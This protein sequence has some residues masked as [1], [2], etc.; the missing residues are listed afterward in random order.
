MI[1]MQGCPMLAYLGC[2]FSYATRYGVEHSYNSQ[3]FPSEAASKLNAV[4]VATPFSM[5]IIGSTEVM[6]KK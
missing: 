1:S 6:N 5:P 3:R 4:R 2:Y